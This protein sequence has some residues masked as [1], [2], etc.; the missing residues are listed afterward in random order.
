[1]TLVTMAVPPSFLGAIACRS[2][3]VWLA[4][5]LPVYAGLGGLSIMVAT[6]AAES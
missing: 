3:T 2:T 5:E 1:M 4:G 6:I